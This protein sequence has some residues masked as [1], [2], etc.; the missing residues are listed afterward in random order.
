MES[1]SE[2]FTTVPTGRVVADIPPVDPVVTAAVRRA[3][4]PTGVRTHTVVG[5]DGLP[6][7]PIE[8]YLAFL[9]DDQASPHTV[10]AYARGL[11]SW[12]ILLVDQDLDWRDF[13]TGAFGSFLAY[14]RTGDLPSVARVGPEPTWLAPASVA[15]RSAAVLAFYCWHAAAHDLTVPMQR[16]YT[17]WGRVRASRYQGMLTGVADH[18][19]PRRPSPV[20]RGRRGNRPRPPVLTPTQVKVI[21]DACA[22]TGESPAS[23]LTAARDRVLFTLLAETGLRLG[24]AL[25]LRHSDLVTGA[26][27]TPRLRVTPR[28]GHPHGCRVKNDK[29][30]EIYISDELEA[31]YS[32]YVW[33]LVDAGID[34]HVADVTDHYVFVNV[35]REPRFAPLSP[36]TV[37]DKIAAITAKHPGQLPA[38][39]SPHW[40]RHT[41]ATALL[42][43]GAAP[44][45]VMRR[46]GH[47]DYQTTLEQYGWVTAEAEMRNLA[48][49]RGFTAG[50]KGLGP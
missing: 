48:E 42:L 11:A 38:G 13:P 3:M 19:Q 50:W 18:A 36:D 14:L 22:P 39:W 1:T 20:Y 15:Q 41:H 37:Y 6:I 16:L 26:G 29:A 33:A 30:R 43:A 8:Q 17:S 9:R 28:E 4:L 49:W 44:H 23:R 25:G 24:E 2:Y 31:L 10:Q 40:L 5:P 27:D 34:L 47:A 45:V 35:A 7:G 21:L 12:W 32:A 46:L